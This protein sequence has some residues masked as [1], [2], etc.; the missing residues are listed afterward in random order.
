MVSQ[1]VEL[2]VLDHLCHGQRSQGRRPFRV[3][4][5]PQSRQQVLQL[6]AVFGIIFDETDGFLTLP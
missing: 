3:Y 2:V 6:L 5:E 1:F 4:V